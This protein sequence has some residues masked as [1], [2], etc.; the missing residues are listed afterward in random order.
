MRIISPLL[1]NV[2]ETDSEDRRRTQNWGNKC[3]IGIVT[4]DD[5]SRVQTRSGPSHISYST[6]SSVVDSFYSF[7]SVHSLT[8][9]HFHTKGLLL[10]EHPA[11]S[12]LSSPQKQTLHTKKGLQR[13]QKGSPEVLFQAVKNEF[14]ESSGRNDVNHR[15]GSNLLWTA[16]ERI[17]DIFE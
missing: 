4:S 5:I 8:F 13:T 2:C 17:R 6:S 12:E 14:R 1:S 15:V 9:D 16:D 10:C 7:G 3:F 11:Y